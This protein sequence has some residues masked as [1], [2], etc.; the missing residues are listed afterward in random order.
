MKYL[1]VMLQPINVISKVVTSK[2]FKSTVALSVFKAKTLRENL[3][4]FII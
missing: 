4:V 3:I 1:C 2:V